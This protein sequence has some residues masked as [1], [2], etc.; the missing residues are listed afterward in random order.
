MRSYTQSLGQLVD[1][2]DTLVAAVESVIHTPDTVRTELRGGRFLLHVIG[3]SG[4]E[5]A[6]LRITASMGNQCHFEYQIGVSNRFGSLDFLPVEHTD[7][8]PDKIVA[9]FI[10]RLREQ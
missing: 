2:T 3:A 5:R 9:E 10:T 6:Q 8:K 7:K 1:E 4:R